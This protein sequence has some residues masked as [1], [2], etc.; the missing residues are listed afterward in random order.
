M[1]KENASIQ[2]LSKGFTAVVAKSLDPLLTRAD[3]EKAFK[4]SPVVAIGKEAFKGCENLSLLT[5]PDGLLRIEEEAFY[6]CISLPNLILPSSVK[7]IGNRAFYGC[8]SLYNA[9]LGTATS[10]LGGNRICFCRNIAQMRYGAGLSSLG[11]DALI[12]CTCG[13]NSFANALTD[14]GEEAF[15]YT[16]IEK[17]VLQEGV[18][19]LGKGAFEGCAK[20]AEVTLPASLKQIDNSFEGCPITTIRYN[21]TAAQ[22]RKIEGHKT[23]GF[24]VHCI[25]ATFAAGKEK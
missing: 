25:D 9:T 24:P 14:I 7:T 1:S 8:G 21:G 2:Y 4:G 12:A 23:L 15:A 13:A 18:S 20:L 17:L 5:L 10:S 6:G 11:G 3:V 16:S 22:F 19:I